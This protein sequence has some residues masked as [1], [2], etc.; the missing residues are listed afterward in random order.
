[1]ISSLKA[2]NAGYEEIMHA[3][4]PYIQ[5]KNISEKSEEKLMHFI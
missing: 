5:M 4:K 2:S 1:M 3:L